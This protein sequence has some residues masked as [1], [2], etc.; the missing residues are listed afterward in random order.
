MRRGLWIGLLV[1]L[2]LIGT[3]SAA[4]DTPILPTVAPIPTP[5]QPLAVEV[6][7]GTNVAAELYT[8]QIISTN[9]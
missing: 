6:L 4:Q 1:T 2:L 5:V 3:S 8:K 9:G 7:T